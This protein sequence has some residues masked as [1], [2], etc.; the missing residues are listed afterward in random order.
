M[1]NFLQYLID[2][3]SVGSTYVMLGLG[4]TL[5]FSV[6]GLIN[7]A[8][9]D[10]LVWGGFGIVMA[11]TLG[12]PYWA[13]V[14]ALILVVVLLSW[15]MGV[16]VFR[17]F[18]NASPTT[19]LLTSFGVSLILQAIGSAVFGDPA[20]NVQ[21]PKWLD[22]SWDIGGVRMN[23]LQLT[24]VLAAIA[25][26][27]ALWVILR[28]TTLGLHMRAVAEDSDVS[29]Y[30]GIKSNR[31]LTT[32]FIV[33]GLIAAIVS[34]LWVAKTGSVSP[35]GGL[36]PTL[37][38]FIVVVIGG[39]GTIRGAVI[40]GLLLGLFESMLTAYLPT[41]LSVYQTTGVFLIL[42]LILLVRPQGV[43]GRNVELSK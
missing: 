28:K 26:L 4:L 30:L 3:V 2:A 6:M 8:Y 20:R 9:G 31:V 10:L 14:L 33:S 36:T 15:L 24:T 17:P 19:L 21:F 23:A 35:Q 38:A 16:A 7:F 40:G 5:V 22:A 11:V 29:Q 25:V 43:F 13:A 37:K 42:M 39:L 1:M 27:V 32:V 12:L 34:F 18:R 41:Q